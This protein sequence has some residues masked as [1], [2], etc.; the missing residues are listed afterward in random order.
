[1]DEIRSIS[2][3]GVPAVESERRAGDPPMLIADAARAHYLLGWQPRY[4]DVATIV[5]TAHDWE[6]TKYLAVAAE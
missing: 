5:G 6:R 3:K 1:M 4:S 2:G